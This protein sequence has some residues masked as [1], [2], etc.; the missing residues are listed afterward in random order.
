[1]SAYLS[2]QMRNQRNWHDIKLTSAKFNSAFGA[3]NCLIGKCFSAHFIL[4]RNCSLFIMI[5]SK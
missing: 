3:A 1:M 4:R 5:T 2:D